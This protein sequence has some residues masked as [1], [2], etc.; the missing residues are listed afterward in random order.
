MCK[1]ADYL[2]VA[3]QPNPDCRP[4]QCIVDSNYL[5]SE[6]LREFLSRSRSNRAVLT[7]YA[8]MEAYKSNTTNVIFQSMEIPAE[9]PKQIIVLKNT[10][11]VG[12]LSGR[13]KGL[14]KRLIDK[15]QTKNFSQFWIVV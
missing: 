4:M 3:Q 10:R 11:M 7:D 8:A 9:F 5:Q 14:Q 2:A 12:A 6:A 15:D 1:L 13:T